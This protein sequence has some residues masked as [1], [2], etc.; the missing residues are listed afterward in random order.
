MRE[1]EVP[2]D[3]SFYKGLKRVCFAVDQDS[4]YVPAKSAGWE[5]ERLATEQALEQLEEEVE[6][7]RQQVVRGE[8]APLA[9]HMAT[10]QM[11]PKL[12]AQHAGLATWRVKRH[13]QP[14][15]F[16]KLSGELLARYAHCLDLPVAA[17]A[18]V[19]AQATR[20]FFEENGDDE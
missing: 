3:R 18:S 12:F 1:D 14:K 19:P 10:R 6:V 9:Y 8:I 16:A 2:Q 11:P 4:H 7:L 17:L 20:V 15:R 13:L 5:V